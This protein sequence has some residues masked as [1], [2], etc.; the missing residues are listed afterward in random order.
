MKFELHSNVVVNLNGAKAKGVII[1]A[2]IKSQPTYSD[3]KT[4]F[5]YLV[6][7]PKWEYVNGLGNVRVFAISEKLI[8]NEPVFI[9]KNGEETIQVLYAKIRPLNYATNQKIL[10]IKTLREIAFEERW[11]LDAAGNPNNMGLAEA[12]TAIE[13]MGAFVDFIREHGRVP[14]MGSGLTLNY[15]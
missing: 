4:C 1:S 12:K 3:T 5:V 13:N 15:L 9:P 14:R 8:E 6:Q 10:A 2:R 7:F 11:Y